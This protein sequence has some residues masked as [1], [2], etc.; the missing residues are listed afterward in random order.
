M[1]LKSVHLS[2]FCASKRK[3]SSWGQQTSRRVLR[4]KEPVCWKTEHVV[5]GRA[6]SL[7]IFEKVSSNLILCFPL[8]MRYPFHADF[9]SCFVH[10]LRCIILFQIRLWVSFGAVETCTWRMHAC[11]PRHEEAGW[12]EVYGDNSQ[13]VF[14]N[15]RY[16]SRHVVWNCPVTE[17]KLIARDFQVRNPREVQTY[18]VSFVVVSNISETSRFL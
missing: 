17:L 4:D 2:V 9:T 12:H 1:L 10:V 3:R 18:V 16:H 11:T 13:E 5:I 15:M 6:L 7:G 8:R 14:C